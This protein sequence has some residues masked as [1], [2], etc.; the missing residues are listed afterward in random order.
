MAKHL[1]KIDLLNL[2]GPLWKRDGQLL[3]IKMGNLGKKE[4]KWLA[5][6]IKIWQTL[7][8]F[9]PGFITDVSTAMWY[10]GILTTSRCARKGEMLDAVSLSLYT[11]D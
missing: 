10:V 1:I 6:S 11:I 7:Y 9:C 3:F 2:Q 4:S 5:Y 8:A